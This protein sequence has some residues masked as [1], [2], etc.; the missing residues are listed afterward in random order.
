[1]SSVY[2]FPTSS[3]RK[4][5][6]TWM[7]IIFTSHDQFCDCND[8]ELHFLV[9]INRD[10]AFRK[11]VSDI[12]NIK[13]LLTGETTTGEEKETPALEDVGFLEGELEK[14]FQEEGNTG[15]EDIASTR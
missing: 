13:C 10:S 9:L 4:Q 6:L 8:P 15:P 14:F 2:K 11:P 12:K 1:M 3:P 7:N 5:E